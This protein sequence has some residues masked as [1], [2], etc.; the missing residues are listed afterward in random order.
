MSQ[1]S[2]NRIPASTRAWNAV[3]SIV[4]IVYGA[5]GLYVDDLF[6][7]SKRGGLYFHQEAAWVMYAAMICAALN[8]LSIVVD[9]YDERD[10]ENNYRLF[11]KVTQI[12]GWIFFATAIIGAI[13]SPQHVTK[14]SQS[15][16]TV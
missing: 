6:I 11:A 1:Y 2:P 4:L 12:A 5:Y 14:N 9:H 10:N 7:P 8:L 16:S 15:K 13:F 3:L